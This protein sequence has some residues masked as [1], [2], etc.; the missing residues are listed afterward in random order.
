[1]IFFFENRD[2][3]EVMWKSLVQPDR[4]QMAINRMRISCWMTKATEHTLRI[5][6]TYFHGDNGCKNSLQ[7]YVYA[8]IAC[9]VSIT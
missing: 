9:L 1:M 8:Y 3:Y 5:S 6:N 2:V 4:R 7:C